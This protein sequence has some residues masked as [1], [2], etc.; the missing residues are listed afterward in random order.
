MVDAKL[1]LF[2]VLVKVNCLLGVRSTVAM[3]QSFKIL[4]LHRF[5]FLL[6]K[7]K[8]III[9]KIRVYKNMMNAIL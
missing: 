7:V 3:P 4:K 5:K 1:T 2:A 8:L 6:P 9:L